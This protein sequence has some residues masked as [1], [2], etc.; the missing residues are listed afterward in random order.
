MSSLKQEPATSF[1]SQTQLSEDAWA[2]T[3]GMVSERSEPVSGPNQSDVLP[4]QSRPSAGHWLGRFNHWS[5]GKKQLFALIVCELVPIL[6][7]G[8]TSTL[9]VQNVLYEQLRYQATSEVAVMETN[10]NIK[11]NQM[12]FGGR[13][14]ADNSAIIEAANFKHRKE[15]LPSDLQAQVKRILQNEVK[16]RQIEYATLV[17]KDLQIIVNAN[18]N[19]AD[20]AIGNSELAELVTRVLN[21]PKQIKATAIVPWSELVQ[22]AA[23][24]PEYANNQDALIRYVVTPVTDPKTKDVLG[25]LVFGDVVN[26]KLPIVENTLKALD[27]GYSAVYLRQPN[28]DFTLAT[29]LDKGKDRDLSQAAVNLPLPNH[30][31]LTEAVKVGQGKSVTQRVT[32]A[33]KTY[34]VAVK[35]LPNR[36]IETP[37][38]PEVVFG[39]QPTALLV[40]GT[41]EDTLNLLMGKTLQQEVIVVV[42]GLGVIILWST[43][44]RR[45]ILSPLQELEQVARQ[46]VQGN[47]QARVE[48]AFGDEVGQLAATFNQMADSMSRSEQSLAVQVE[49]AQQLNDITSAIRQ[50]LQM[51]QILD[52]AVRQSREAIATDRV[53][54]YAF[55]PDWDGT[56]VA[57]SVSPGW[58][59]AL[60]ANIADPCF[61]DR[62]VDQYRDGRIKA[63]DDIY[64][65]GLAH[66]HVNQLEF[67]GVRANLVVPI[68]CSGQLYGLLI[69]HHCQG[70]R[71]WDEAE[72]A[73]MGQIA[74]QVGFALEQSRLLADQEKS[75]KMAEAMEKEQRQQ[76]E[77][78]Q[79]QLV[80][81]LTDVEGVA[82]GDLTVRTDVFAGEIGTV[83][84]FFNSIVENL[85]QV[86]TQVKQTVVQVNRSLGDN[87]QAIHQLA[88]Q[89][90]VQAEDITQTL[91]TIEQ[92]TQAIYRVAEQA[93]QAAAVT[94]H[95]STSVEASRMAMDFTVQTIL[96]LQETIG[97]TTRKV[98]SLGES[99]HQISKV[100]SLINDIALQ[101]NVLAINAGIEASRA[102]GEGKGFAVVAEEV[103]ALA[104][105]SAAAT[106]E[107]GQI[108]DAIQ[109]ETQD[110]VAAMQLG[111]NQ[112][113]EGTR[114]VEDAKRSIEKVFELSHQVD[115]LVKS[116][117][118]AAIAQTHTSQTIAQVMQ[119]I[120]QVSGETSQSSRQVATSLR[121]TVEI[122]QQLQESV[123]T[124]K[125]D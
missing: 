23:P 124:F 39:Q 89:A 121:E 19:R 94:H 87:G 83:A 101:T 2:G 73:F 90:L 72:M 33:D 41:P 96:G 82:D 99:S 116:V 36:V 79:Q 30:D 107:I 57:E 68:L 119:E 104:A 54:V 47:R 108:V 77:A 27:S 70:S 4:T 48:V 45:T 1:T 78:L 122:A 8:V 18:A 111:N 66:C 46:F 14:Q 110:V 12:G 51:E 13:G 44:F 61:A 100:V 118:A 28:G 92:M 63:T 58:P 81:L 103:G 11:I 53:I 34:T 91:D 25:V 74:V 9:V 38:G 120:A 35:A 50:S 105:R 102:G 42:L 106:K 55:N 84:D 60:G 88:E 40:R 7:L 52:T 80:K 22:E 65:A 31:L 86:V 6:G 56:I 67:F 20:E 113:S 49:Q 109:R 16:A 76:K 95:A 59:L 10:Y 24:V 43:V 71:H 32:F 37:S 17:G 64:N 123:E 5:I 3:T 62:Y 114:L 97:G 112:V 125:V 98:Q 75:L 117:S 29:A 85:R 115:E 15:A 69:A 93:H 26:G 21:D